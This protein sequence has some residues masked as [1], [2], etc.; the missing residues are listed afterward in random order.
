M[1]R[2]RFRFYMY[3]SAELDRPILY[4]TDQQLQL[5]SMFERRQLLKHTQLV[6]LRLLEHIHW[7]E[8]RVQ[9]K[10]L[11]ELTLQIRLDLH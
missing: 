2:E 11:H 9:N 10:Q 8:M 6:R 5:E 1:Y 4:H 7:S 3:M